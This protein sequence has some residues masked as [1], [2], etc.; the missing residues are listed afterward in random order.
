MTVEQERAITAIRDRNRLTEGQTMIIRRAIGE[1][2][3]HLTITDVDAIMRR[4]D[5]LIEAIPVLFPT[6]FAHSPSWGGDRA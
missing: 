1:Q 2:S 6:E 4:I 3:M 5:A